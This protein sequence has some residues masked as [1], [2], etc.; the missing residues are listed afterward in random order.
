MKGILATIVLSLVLLLPLYAQ[1]RDDFSNVSVSGIRKVTKSGAS[2]NRSYVEITLFSGKSFSV[3]NM[4][5]CLR[6]GKLQPTPFGIGNG[7][8]LQGLIEMADW[9]KLKNGDPLW[10]SWGCL[11][12]S[13][14]E[15]MKP[16]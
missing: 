4:Y 14:Y 11:Q 2:K 8:A 3:G 9:K 10:L 16:F 13:A 15:K 7:F 5:Y 1:V 12:P 6:I